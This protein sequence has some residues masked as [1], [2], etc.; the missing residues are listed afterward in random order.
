M[1]QHQE[2]LRIEAARTMQLRAAQR[3]KEQVF[4]SWWRRAMVMRN[5]RELRR[6]MREIEMEDLATRAAAGAVVRMQAAVRRRAAVGRAKVERVARAAIG[7]EGCRAAPL[8]I[9]HEIRPHLLDPRRSEQLCRWGTL[10]SP[11]CGLP[12]A[13]TPPVSRLL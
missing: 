11:A 4:G 12:S 9:D 1:R 2:R 5:V 13:P 10:S 8:G 6:D 3:T 7:K